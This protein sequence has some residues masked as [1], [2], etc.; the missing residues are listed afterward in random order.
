MFSYYQM[1]ILEEFVEATYKR[2]NITNPLQ[3]TVNELSQRLNVWVHM[4]DVKS[5]ALEAVPGMYSMFLDSRLDPD[6]QR[7]DFLH[8]L[9][10]LLRHA[11]NQMTMP[12]SF[13]RM[14]EIEAEQFV[15]YAAMPFSMISKLE[16]PDRSS[17]AIAYLAETFSVPAELAERRLDQ[18]QRRTLQGIWYDIVRNHE[19]K[20]RHT[21]PVW[22]S[23]TRRVINQL[24][25]QLISRGLPGYEDHGLV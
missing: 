8:E 14:Q 15:L 23:E 16:I 2:V 3:I 19:Q 6:Q 18:L 25:R 20:Q 17:L 10:H 9:C 13:T 24:D 22:S 12:E 7:L 4:S 11:G 1:T 21:E 5:R